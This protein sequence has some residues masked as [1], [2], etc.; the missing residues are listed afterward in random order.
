MLFEIEANPAGGLKV[1]REIPDVGGPI[2]QVEGRN[3]V[4]KSVALRLLVLCSGAQPY[5]DDRD[6]WS[7]LRDL[8][9]P[10][11]V[12]VSGLPGERRIVWHL[13]PAG[14]PEDPAPVGPWLGT[15]EI[16][17]QQAR[18]EDALRLLSVAHVSGDL[19]LEGTI[20]E[21]IARDQKALSALR[22]RFAEHEQKV[23]E[24]L[25]G[26]RRDLGRADSRTLEDLVAEVEQ[27]H[28]VAGDRVKEVEAAR[29]SLAAVERA[30][31]LRERQRRL[32]DDVPALEA[33]EQD[34]DRQ[35][36]AA[37]QRVAEVESRYS[38]LELGRRRDE[39]LA[40][41][42]EGV[43][44]AIKGRVRRAEN[45]RVRVAQEA[46]ALGFADDEAD[47]AVRGE[48]ARLRAERDDLTSQRDLID[49]TPRVKQ[50]VDDLSARLGTQRAH[51]IDDQIVAVLPDASL[52][53][54]ELRTGVASRQSEL[55]TYEPEPSSAALSDRIQ[56]L[57]ARIAR[58]ATLIEDLQKAARAEEL[59][60]ESRQ[61][62]EA[63]SQRLPDDEATEFRELEHE[64]NEARA[65]H[66][67][68]VEMRAVVRGK[69]GELGAGDMEGEARELEGLL[70]A[71][72]VVADDLEALL[73]ER[74]A[75]L[76]DRL[77]EQKVAADAVT[78]LRSRLE[79]AQAE[80]DQ[81]V[82][83]LSAG[84]DYKW[85]RAGDIA[86]PSP[87]LDHEENSGR[88]SGLAAAA[89]E[90]ERHLDAGRG[91]LAELDGALDAWANRRGDERAT[92]TGERVRS[93]Y[94]KV[95][96]ELL[97]GEEIVEALFD[98]GKFLALDLAAMAVTWRTEEGELRTRG[99]SSF[100]SG[101]RAFAYTRTRLQSLKSEA[102][103]TVVALD[104]FGAFLARD[105]L[106]QLV[107]FLEHEVIGSIADQVII[108]L[109]LAR[110]YEA[111]LDQTTG[112]LH[113]EFTSRVQELEQSGY[114]V[115]AAEWL[116]A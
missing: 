93:Y 86:V 12:R 48:L 78:A 113:D 76:S 63:L 46:S 21:R 43:E 27:A 58:L 53:V 115:R 44:Q 22:E 5:A 41:Q 108:V 4:G 82:V 18:L 57:T 38:E 90:L 67:S 45:A 106:K 9:G 49:S 65:S 71:F 33:R 111:E 107:A 7:T 35:I 26:L 95:F 88:L 11:V 24:R 29:A 74:A 10:V 109:P 61:Q 47:D 2:A 50:M 70:G 69:I 114:F 64:L 17:G 8:L 72:G 37:A 103:T 73:G 40:A 98:N 89:G 62:L 79:L 94:E 104:E 59:V 54:R 101:E 19:T 6:S 51:E 30:A 68:L 52:T 60:Q 3:G 23:G 16:D 28:A 75:E 66:L 99:L 83:V 85:L 110:D 20:L 116:K 102:A 92:P 25:E 96:G 1:I 13:N 14:W 56:R 15:V 77:A 84:D 32:N 87:D 80:F 31:E 105:R 97:S 42:I 100:S 39:A 34:L 55:A 36:D 91:M 81:A 112:P